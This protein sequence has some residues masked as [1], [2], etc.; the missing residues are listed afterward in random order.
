LARGYPALVIIPLIVQGK[1]IGVVTLSERER[2]DWTEVDLRPYQVTA[3]QLAIALSSRRQQ[4][5]LQEGEQR[6][7]VL[8]ERQRIARE[9]HDS[10]SQ[11]MFSMSLVAQSL[12]SAY[13]KD[14]KEGDRRVS[15]LMELSH[16]ARTEMRALLAELRSSHDTL[17]AEASLAQVQREGLVKALENHVASV[18]K[19]GLRVGLETAS[20]QRQPSKVEETLFRIAQEALTNV[21]KH[22]KAQQVQVRLETQGDYA[23][24]YIQDDGVGFLMANAVARESAIGL[25]SMRERVQA[26]AGSLQIDSSPGAGTRLEVS[27]PASTT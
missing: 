25:K 24:L 13:N 17:L 19:D 8:E 26:L 23:H 1:R 6:I 5:Q 12:G 16:L 18:T 3:A 21:L 22:A 10:V 2:H 4:Q 20:Y 14:V 15:R 9:L 27:I 7:A 11:L